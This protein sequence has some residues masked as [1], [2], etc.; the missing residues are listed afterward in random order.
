MWSDAPAHELGFGKTAENYPKKMAKDFNELT[1]WWGDKDN[2]GY[3]DYNSKRLILFTPDLPWWN[4]IRNSWDNVIHYMSEAG[5]G[6]E[7]VNYK[8]IIDAI[9]YSI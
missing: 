1:Q 6:L 5:K 9:A 7:E 2:T 8:Q 3:M 4:E